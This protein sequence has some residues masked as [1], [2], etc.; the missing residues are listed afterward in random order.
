M[1]VVNLEFTVTQLN[2]LRSTDTVGQIC[3]TLCEHILRYLSK[4]V[5][6]GNPLMSNRVDTIRTMITWN[7]GILMRACGNDLRYRGPPRITQL[8]VERCERANDY[9]TRQA[10][11]LYSLKAVPVSLL[12][13]LIHKIVMDTID[14]ISP[15]IVT[16]TPQ[17]VECWNIK[18]QE[19]L[20]ELFGALD[21]KFRFKDSLNLVMLEVHL[22]DGRTVIQDLVK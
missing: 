15:D 9:V 11:D 3:M 7:M 8:Y 21:L 13:C 20:G 1:T 6:R 14:C 2:N 19:F 4:V 10:F 16:M 22:P 18:M 12:V 17:R 5:L